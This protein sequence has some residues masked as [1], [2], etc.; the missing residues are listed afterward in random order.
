MHS[1]LARAGSYSVGLLIAVVSVAEHA[2]AAVS[3]SAP[4]IDGSSLT[5]GL[6]LLAAAVMIVRSRRRGK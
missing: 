1:R 3:V 2:L 4:E 5:T 6:G